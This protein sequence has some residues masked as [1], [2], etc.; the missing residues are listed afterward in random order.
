M[1]CDLLRKDSTLP[2]LERPLFVTRV[3]LHPTVSSPV[4]VLSGASL[5]R[6][7]EPSVLDRLSNVIGSD[8]RCAR[9]IRYGARQFEHPVIAPRRER[10][11]RNRLFRK[12]NR[13]GIGG[14]QAVDLLGL[15]VGVGLSLALDLNFISA[16]DVR[17]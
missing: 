5:P 10:Q 16:F 15:E 6:P 9:E 11:A 17:A 13:G 14:A 8:D 4:G 7:I 2:R 12:R 3:D 1:R